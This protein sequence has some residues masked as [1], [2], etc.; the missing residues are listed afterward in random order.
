MKKIRVEFEIEVEDSLT[1][2]EI[3]DKV[4]KYV[5]TWRDCWYNDE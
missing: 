5:N 3:H 2:K 4:I 1:D